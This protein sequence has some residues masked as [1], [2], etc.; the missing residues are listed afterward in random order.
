MSSF[1]RTAAF[2]VATTLAA[3][4]LGVAPTA[5]ASSRAKSFKAKGVPY[6]D[7]FYNNPQ[8]YTY[9]CFDGIEGVHKTI[10]PFRAP[11]DGVLEAWIE[12]FQGDWDIG[13]FDGSG[14]L[15]A[16]PWGSQ[17]LTDTA[18]ER[19]VLRMKAGEKGALGAC[20]WSSLQTELMVH[21]RFT[22][23]Y[24]HLKRTQARDFTS[25][26]PGQKSEL[27]ERV[28]VNFVFVGY[29]EDEV[30]ARDFS[31]EL[32]ERYRPIVRARNIWYGT[33]DYLGIEYSYDYD[34]VFA[35]ND[36]EDRFF[37]ELRD[38]GTKAPLT[39]FQT[40]YNQ[41]EKNVVDLET[42][43]AIPAPKVERWLAL[44]PPRGVD[45]S[46]YTVFFIDWHGE[47]G[48]EPHIY[49]KLGEPDVDTNFEWGTFADEQTIAWGGTT[50]DDPETGLGTTHRV[51]FHDLS[52]GPEAW[53][54]NYVVDTRDINGNG[55][56]DVRM[57]PS[58]EY[59]RGGY[60][61]P[62]KLSSDLGKI[63]RYVAINLLFTTSPLYSP[64]IK[65]P[66]IPETINLD[67]NT[68]EGIPGKDASQLWVQEKVVLEKFREW[69]PYYELSVDE[70]DLEVSNPDFVNCY[71]M[72]WWVWY[73][74]GCYPDRPYTTWANLFLLGVMGLGETFDDPKAD[75]EAGAFNYAL[76]DGVGATWGY[77]DDNWLDGT[78]SFTHTFVDSSMTPYLGMTHILTHEFGHHFGA[79]HPHDGFDYETGLDYGGWFDRT[80][81]AWVGTQNNTVMN[82]LLSN[83]EFSQFD[84]DNM[85]RWMTATYLTAVNEITDRIKHAEGRDTAIRLLAEAD[86]FASRAEEAFAWHG[87]RAAAMLAKQ[88]YEA[89]RVAARE[90]GVKI[91]GRWTA[92]TLRDE[93]QEQR[94]ER[95]HRRYHRMYVDRPEDFI[96]SE[97][98][99][100]RSTPAR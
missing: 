43:L 14:E 55:R 45:T 5:V 37:S 51:W 57:P 83:N 76:P 9:T 93:Q 63:A 82:Y 8:A 72:F 1:R 89:A 21:Y 10:K 38:L 69:L 7:Y 96:P 33:P 26:D 53:T 6:A 70:Q 23:G 18:S 24:P 36:Y 86:T 84:H 54:R 62:A 100:N 98:L 64:S 66:D 30:D 16:F 42:N 4:L 13:I 47:A 46:E 48:F 81:F 74:P 60:N 85:D 31:K 56:E 35:D 99:D 17:W 87:Y 12:G 58:W 91:R 59:R 27:R 68:Y 97:L 22:P 90:A 15:A 75:Y 67:L 49:T 39:R 92:T 29:D 94:R 19:T 2:T 73:G 88:S 41:Q 44:N 77:A 71:E 50:A 79:S 52:A 25:I 95:M 40:L 80:R 11:T 78:Q 65:S 3:G 34:T 28:P 32:P 20:N 61:K